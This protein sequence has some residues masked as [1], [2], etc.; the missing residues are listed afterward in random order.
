[1][2]HDP[3]TIAGLDTTTTQRLRDASLALA[4]RIAYERGGQGQVM[5]DK[6]ARAADRADTWLDELA[7][8]QRR[9]GRSA[10]G[11]VAAINQPAKLV[12][13]DPDGTGI[14]RAGFGRGF[15]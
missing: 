3:E 15:T 5:P 13:P 6:F 2:K 11:R 7:A 12:D 8:G 1:M 10:G 4:A 14:S 9:L